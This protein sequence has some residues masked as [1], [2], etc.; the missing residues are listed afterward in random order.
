MKKNS[1]TSA[2][3]HYTENVNLLY[4]II[5]EGLRF[6]FCKESISDKVFIGAPMISFCDIPITHSEE[7]REKYGTSAIGLSKEYIISQSHKYNIAPVTYLIKNDPRLFSY[8]GLFSKKPTNI[9][10]GFLKRDVYTHNDEEYNAYDECEWRITVE[11]S[12]DQPWFT[13]EEEYNKWRGRL[14]N[15]NKSKTPP[16]EFSKEEPFKFGVKDIDYIIVSKKSNIPNLINK[17]QKLEKVCGEKIDEK[18]KAMLLSKVISFE[19]IMN[20]F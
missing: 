4:K 14:S 16:K 13:N 18:E 10:F 20:D 15:D 3:F 7:H 5:E 12:V 19:Q 11:N 6:S 8:E 9:I 1:H 17:L 2:F